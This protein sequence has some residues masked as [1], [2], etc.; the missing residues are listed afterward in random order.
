MT[1]SGSICDKFAVKP[2]NDGTEWRCALDGADGVLIRKY[3]LGDTG[4]GGGAVCYYSTKDFTVNGK[5]CHYLE[6]S[7]ESLG[8]IRWCPCTG[9][10]SGYCAVTTSGDIGAGYANTQAILAHSKHAS[11]TASNCAAKACAEY[12]TST[13]EAGEWF[14]PNNNE[15]LEI[16]KGGVIHFSVTIWSSKSNSSSSAYYFKLSL[17]DANS[18]STGKGAAHGVFAMR[19]F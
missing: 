2:Q 8:N 12:S 7:K 6:C 19:A 13:T 4:L 1:L 14:L 9:G 16:N 10:I 15:A 5:T 11:V 3:A 18:N 17:N